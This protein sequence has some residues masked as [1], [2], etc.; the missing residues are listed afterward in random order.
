LKLDDDKNH[1]IWKRFRFAI[2]D[3]DKAKDYPINFVCML[4][5]QIDPRM[6][7]SS[8]FVRFFEDKSLEVAKQ[9]LVDALKSENDSEVKKEIAR[10]LKHLDSASVCE[11]VCVLCGGPLQV[12]PRKRSR[13]K[14]C[15]ECFKKKTF[16]QNRTYLGPQ[17]K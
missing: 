16:S 9:L 8:T 2:V 12:E 17:R 6:K 11:K 7:G 14:Y 10:R 4:P 1:S 3:L 5:M 13:Q 15:S